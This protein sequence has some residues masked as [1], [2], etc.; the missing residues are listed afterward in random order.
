[1]KKLKRNKYPFIFLSLLF[2]LIN[3]NVTAQQ[4]SIVAEEVVKL[5]Y[6]NENNSLQYLIVESRLKKGKKTE[7]QKNKTFQLYLDSVV[8]E[9]LI[10]KVT[11]D[12]AGKAKSFLPLTLKAKWDAD[13]M[14]KF[15]AVVPGKEDEVAAEF[16][17]TKAKI[18]IDTASE[19]GSRSITVT[20]KKY[21]N[22]EWV[23][24]NEVEMKIGIQRL[25][26]ILSA[27]DEATYTTDSSGTVTIAI[28]KDSLPGDVK[29]NIILAASVEENDV[30]GNL[31]IQKTVAWGV[32]A[33][34][35]NNFF[36][37]RTLWSTRFNTPIWLL[38]IAY[39]IILSV[40][41][42]LVYLIFQL[43]KIKKLGKKQLSGNMG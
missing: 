14:H 20:I 22:G 41:G 19:E 1:M 5:K 21:E 39:S 43:I 16:E 8:A 4:D 37:Q 12:N 10:A 31:S 36:N 9:N 3:N 2:S 25:G 26:G 11:T 23:P 38:A 32:P 33:K 15:M 29:G 35:D 18:E 6:Y 34:Y 42:T 17:I 27:G 40:W 24:V 28:S 30:V 13:P 7:P